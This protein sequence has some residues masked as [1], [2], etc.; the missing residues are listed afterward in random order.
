M[1]LGQISEEVIL[2]MSPTSGNCG[3][4]PP[5]A[6][7]SAEKVLAGNPRRDDFLDFGAVKP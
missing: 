1:Q 4:F 2:F 6:V 7:L 3:H 5:H